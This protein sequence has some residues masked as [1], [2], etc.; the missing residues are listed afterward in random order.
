MKQ[1]QSGLVTVH[2]YLTTVLL[3][4][5]G[6]PAFNEMLICRHAGKQ[7]PRANGSTDSSLPLPA[8]R[9]GC[10]PMWCTPTFERGPIQRRK[11]IQRRAPEDGRATASS[12]RRRK[13]SHSLFIQNN[14]SSQQPG[15]FVPVI[16]FKFNI[17]LPFSSYNHWISV[18]RL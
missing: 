3:C 10:F 14:S 13:A 17:Y 8:F 2:Y 6:T 5:S 16:P 11:L 18:D 4:L 1:L 7:A 9:A 12:R 15:P